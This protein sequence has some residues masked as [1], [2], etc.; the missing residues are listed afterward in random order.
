[1]T[2]RE[3]LGNLIVQT[4]GGSIPEGEVED[5]YLLHPEAMKFLRWLI[6]EREIIDCSEIRFK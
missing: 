2:I 6:Y 4:F 3:L 5:K 1:M